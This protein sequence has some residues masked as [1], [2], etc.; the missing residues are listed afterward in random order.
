MVDVVT[1]KRVIGFSMIFFGIVW[2]MLDR[3]S[4]R[5]SGDPYNEGFLLCIK[6][7]LFVGI[8]FVV[9]GA[10]LLIRANIPTEFEQ[11]FEE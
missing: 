7:F 3:Y 4:C 8:I 10:A 6:L 2:M 5:I 9:C 11:G 1:V